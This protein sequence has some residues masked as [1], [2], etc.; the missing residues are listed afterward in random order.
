VFLA[1][2]DDPADYRHKKRAGRGWVLK[3]R[4]D[5]G[6]AYLDD[7]TGCTIWA[8]RPAMCRT[9]HC[10]KW[11]EWW[12]TITSPEE[13]GRQLRAGNDAF[14]AVVAAGRKHR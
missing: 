12:I 2:S 10:G 11:F 7:S 1:T 5:G 3:T 8:K 14:R 9:F 6:C 13:R 4:P